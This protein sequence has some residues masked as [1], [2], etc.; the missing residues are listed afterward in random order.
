MRRI[1]PVLVVLL[2]SAVSLAQSVPE[3]FARAKEQVRRGAWAD[4]LKTLDALEVEA[5]KPGNESFRAQLPAPLAFYRGVAHASLG[6]ADQASADF[7][8]FLALQ[9]NAQID[10]AQYPKKAV[11]AFE[12]AQKAVS[13]RAPSLADAYRSFQPRPDA[14]SRYPADPRWAEG[15]VHWIMT[16]ADKRAW[17]SLP[18]NA[19]R[20]DFIEKFWA[21]RPAAFRAEFDR[22][23]AFADENLADDAE[24]PGSLTDRGMVFILMG[25]PTFAGRKPLRTGEDASDNAGMSSVGSHDEETAIRG[26]VNARPNQKAPG[27]KISQTSAQYNGPGK[28]AVDSSANRM[29]V[30][31]YRRELL[32]KGVPYQQVDFEFVTKQGYGVNTLQREPP[33]V[34]TLDAAKATVAPSAAPR[35]P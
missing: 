1:A 7:G 32:P 18:P 13:D 21:S 33:P 19:D 35:A 14:A 29:E 20:L 6:Q 28:K 9:P 11:A 16:E 27:G 2:L 3:L 4:A 34:T 25:P 8:N 31:H 23:V 26:M 17:S 10:A 5:A 24:Q 30:W 22:R 15:P 12:K